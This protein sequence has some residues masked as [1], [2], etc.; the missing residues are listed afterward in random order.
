MATVR[1]TGKVFK[2][3]D[4]SRNA[5]V[6]WK[7]QQN[8]SPFTEGVVPNTDNYKQAL[9]F[10]ADKAEFPIMPSYTA[11]QFDKGEADGGRPRRHEQLLQHQLDPAGPAVREGAA[12]LPVRVRHAGHVPQP[13]RVGELGRVR[14]RRQPL[15]GQQRVL[16]QLERRPTQTL[17]RSG[18]HH[19][20]LGA[21]NFMII[22][23][24]AGLTPAARRRRSSCG[25]STSAGTTTCSTTCSYHGQDLSIVWD[26][27]GRHA[28]LRRHAR[29]HVGL[30]RRPP[31]VHDQ[32]H[33]A[34]PLRLQTGD[35]SVLDGSA[36]TVTYKTSRVLETATGVTLNDN[37]RIVDMFQKAGV[38]LTPQTGSLT[39]LAEG[40][41]ATAS[42]TTT[43]PTLQLTSPANATDGFTYSGLPGRP[44][45]AYQARNPIWGTQGSPNAQ[46]WLE[47]D[48]GQPTRFDTREAVLL[49]QQA[50]RHGRQ[51]ATGPRRRTA[52]ST[53]A[54]TT[55]VDVP[56]Q[57]KSPANPAPELQQGHV[58][59]GHRATRPPARRPARGTLGVG[60]KEVQLFDTGSKTDTPGQRRRDGARDAR[61]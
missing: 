32:R 47:I 25:R 6:P 22:D 40:K 9:R 29:G 45:A 38:D 37:A 5:L 43:T 24:I 36:T 53:R 52:C 33:R 23:D 17:G 20:I 15:P 10:Y 14:Q 46:D 55:W 21:F 39:N 51:H 31:R 41:P 30:R 12:R 18:I 27:P 34:R 60:V 59:G 8:F 4:V 49:R 35:V 58:P 1:N 28:L 54:A 13:A 42:F 26:K 19:N 2:M 44:P 48:L 56:G 3:R 50:V 11:N 57:A 61:R 7:D 16:L